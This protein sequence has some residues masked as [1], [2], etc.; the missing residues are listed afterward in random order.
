M[1]HREN[2]PSEIAEAL[3]REFARHASAHDRD[4]SF[5]FENFD[6]LNTAGLVAL[7]V[8]R[9]YGGAGAGLFETCAVVGAIA[10]GDASTA[11]VLTMQYVAHALLSL[12]PRWPHHLI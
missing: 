4:G 7:T 5:P 1:K 8:P 3:A 10:R 12:S 9:Q 2:N 6:R 11:L